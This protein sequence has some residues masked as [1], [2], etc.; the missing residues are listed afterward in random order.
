MV[1]GLVSRLHARYFTGMNLYRDLL[2][3]LSGDDSR[4]SLGTFMVGVLS[5][6]LLLLACM[7]LGAEPN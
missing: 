1:F 6:A 7:A 3:V 5:L 2:A 4:S